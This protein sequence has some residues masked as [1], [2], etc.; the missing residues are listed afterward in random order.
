MRSKTS[1][2]N[3]TLFKKNMSRFWPLWGLASF[4]GS[5]F[6]LTMLMQMI[7]FEDLR[8]EVDTV[9]QS[10]YAALTMFVPV[11]SLLY[12]VLCAAAVWSYLY[13]PRSVG[14]MH[15]L[16]I[17]RE[18]LF[19]TNFLS[20]MA[21]MLIPYVITGSL[22]V[23]IVVLSR[24]FAAK[25]LMITVLGVLGESFFYFCSATFVAFLTGNVF[26]MPVIYFLLHF[27][28]PLVS[29]LLRI[30]QS[31]Y[32]YGV[33]AI[34]S[35]TG[36]WLCPTVYLLNNV[37]TKYN[38]KE[39]MTAGGYITN[40]LQSV[41]LTNVWVI[42]AYALAGV[43]LLALAYAFYRRRQSEG[44]SDVAAVGW[45]RPVFRYGG[46]LL[47]GVAG[48]MLLYNLMWS[49]IRHGQSTLPMVICMAIMGL[50]GYY[51]VSMLLEKSLHVFR[52]S[53]IP[54]A[55]VAV[56]ALTAICC[57]VSFDIFHIESRVPQADQVETISLRVEGNVYSLKAG[58]QDDLIAQ[59]LDLHQAIVDDLDYIKAEEI[60]DPAYAYL[61]LEYELTNG[62]TLERGY[63]LQ[64]RMDRLSQKDTF[65]Y[66]LDQL[67][68]SI[69][70]K[71]LRLK[72][73]PNVEITSGY[74][75][76]DNQIHLD[77]SAEQ[78][79]KIRAAV[80]RDAEK[81][82]WGHTYWTN[83]ETQRKL[84]GVEISMLEEVDGEKEYNSIYLYIRPEM[85]ETIACLRDM[86]LMEKDGIK[87]KVGSGT[88]DEMNYD[89]ATE[90][91]Y[92]PGE[93]G[94]IGIIGG[95]DGP[96]QVYVTEG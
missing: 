28:Q 87:L 54:G 21:M 42:A 77:L 78:A 26:A 39:V 71:L 22:T 20:G 11:V 40:E 70:M 86:G 90:V 74:L 36:E 9:M 69:P 82:N 15:R 94:S 62:Q 59:V 65:D 95:A 44:A 27:L 13:N 96:T 19:V 57:S 52:K 30:L 49:P 43:V 1:F 81:G 91:H 2:F 72:M 48:G 53:S 64:L 58:E 14:M 29:T 61:N 73:L 41:E 85:T 56:V 38:Y 16:P 12:A 24:A 75:T 45:M 84:A 7:R 79:E 92:G 8:L 89:E 46:A 93:A 18:G 5:L 25:A 55:A 67:V 50:M 35:H 60:V 4:V 17:R 66:K 31:S 10:L 33:Y 23:L 76:D 32:Y 63:G 3:K 6:P 51:G 83:T 47:C 80:A 34:Y 37:E 68:N 88:V